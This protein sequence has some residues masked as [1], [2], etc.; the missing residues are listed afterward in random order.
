MIVRHQVGRHRRS[1]T[2]VES[3]VILTVTLTIL[4][5]LIVG[6]IGIMR[7]QMVALLAREATR[8]A[9]VRGGQYRV[10]HGLAETPGDT[11]T[12]SADLYSNGMA[13][14]AG[15]TNLV[16]VATLGLDTSQ[17]TYSCTWSPG[18]N[19]QPD[20]FATWVDTSKVDGSGNYIVHANT[21]TVTVTYNWY[22]E[23]LWGGPIKFTSTSQMQISY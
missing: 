16:N 19:S 21:V 4:I 7:Y 22:P 6:G 14:F 2:M 20:N 18:S 17:L 8:A 11:P 12:W 15:E 9:S 13:R 5:G 3:V 1:A 23:S 10:D